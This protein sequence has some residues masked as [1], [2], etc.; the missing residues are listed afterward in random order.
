MVLNVLLL[1]PLGF[2]SVAAL[3]PRSLPVQVLKPV[4]LAV[5]NAVRLQTRLCTAS[6]QLILDFKC[7]TLEQTENIQ[8]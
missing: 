2:I 6:A 3:Q 7:A 1:I 5:Q 8:D 4:T